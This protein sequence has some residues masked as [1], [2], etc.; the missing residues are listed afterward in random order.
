MKIQDSVALITGGGSGIGEKVA[1]SLAKKGCKLGLVDM[2]EEAVSRVSNKI[3]EKGGSSIAICADVTKEADSEKFV[4]EVIETFKKL[5]IVIPCAGIIQDGFLL[6]TDKETQKVKKKLDL[7]KWTKVL[8]VNLT[9]SFLTIRDACEAISDGN[10]PGLVIPISSIN[11]V[12]QIGQLNYSSSKVALSL[13]PKILVGEFKIKKIDNIRVVGIAPGYTATTL[14]ES[15]DK[16]ILDSLISNVHLGRL[17]DPEEIASLIL[18]CAENEAL[19]GTTIEITGGI[20]HPQSI[21]K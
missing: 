5:N 4:Y 20:C 16:K 2:D 3:N 11:K 8:D 7:K 19:N 9:G 10:W 21:C 15:M 6:S 18:H 12:G 1:I 14:L 13:F 17:I